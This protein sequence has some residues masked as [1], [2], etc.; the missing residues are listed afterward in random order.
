MVLPCGEMSTTLRC[1][2]VPVVLATLAGCLAGG[3]PGTPSDAVDR[4]A[5]EHGDAGTV[6][7]PVEDAPVPD[8]PPDLSAEADSTPATE[9]SSCVPD[10]SGRQCGDDG[11]GGRCGHCVGG[12][13][14]W[15]G[16]CGCEPHCPAMV[17][18]DAGPF[19]MGCHDASVG[20]CEPTEYPYHEVNV[21]AFFIDVFEVTVAQ[22]RECVVAA[23]CSEPGSPPAE[24]NWGVPGKD[25]HPVWA[26]SWVQADQ[27]CSWAGKRLCTEAEWEKAARGTDGRFYPWGNRDPS[28]EL[29]VMAV[30]SAG[31]VLSDGCGTGS[32]FEVG[33]LPAGQSPYGVMDM[34][35][36]VNEHVE[37]GFH[38]TYLGAPSDG[39]AWEPGPASV[40]G[41]VRVYRGGDIRDVG[42]GVSVPMRYGAY[43][44]LPCAAGARCC[45]S[46]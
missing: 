21:P 29:A 6:E 26:L 30:E 27:Y 2:C 11:C 4:W 34:A 25:Q 36:N 35:G 45:K 46:P 32:T 1:W 16:T 10:C 5:S 7:S 8:S 3:T 24:A 41:T 17:F 13:S 15:N 19:W 43:E 33:S 39:S 44:N 31:V 12:N 38:D 28:C 14:C 9:V 42:A 18:V 20:W 37:D 23:V 40:N 22:Y